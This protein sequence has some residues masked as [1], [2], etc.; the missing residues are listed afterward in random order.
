M[1]VRI[2]LLGVGGAVLLS[3]TAVCTIAPSRAR[4]APRLDWLGAVLTAAARASAKVHNVSRGREPVDVD[5]SAEVFARVDSAECPVL[6]LV[7][8]ILLVT[9]S[10]FET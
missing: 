5:E 2:H 10:Y 4:D 6:N 1:R 7:G 3:A 9:A 8:G